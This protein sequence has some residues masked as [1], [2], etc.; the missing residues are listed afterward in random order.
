MVEVASVAAAIAAANALASAGSALS[1]LKAELDV[2]VVGGT[3]V[4]AALA[5]SQG[6]LEELVA[7]IHDACQD[8][9]AACASAM[10]EY[11]VP[12]TSRKSKP[13]RPAAIDSP[14]GFP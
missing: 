2:P 5:V 12:S 3:Q 14:G 11:R 13:E 10:A 4:D 8:L 7:E 1:A 9:D 6:R